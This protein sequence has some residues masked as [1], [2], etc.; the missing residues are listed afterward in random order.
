[1]IT[2]ISFRKEYESRC[3][4]GCNCLREQ[5]ESDFEIRSFSKEDEAA[6][7]L[8]E[9]LLE[10]RQAK[11]SNVVFD[12][13]EHF[14]AWSHGGATAYE[15][16]GVSSIVFPIGGD[17]WSYEGISEELLTTPEGYA[18]AETE[19]T[20]FAAQF[21]QLV[22]ASIHKREEEKA[23]AAAEETRRLQEAKEAQEKDARRKAYEA[24]RTEFESKP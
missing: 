21:L 16:R 23:L 20:A 5:R 1:M 14:A 17:R 19:N 12:R 3:A 2:I 10:G 7:W 13:A 4:G 22:R 9:R 11:F 24:L 8:A 18:A 6:A 15:A